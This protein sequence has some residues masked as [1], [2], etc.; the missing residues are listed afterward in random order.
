MTSILIDYSKASDTVDH[1]ILLKKLQNMNFAK[2]TIKIICSYLI[3]RYQYLQTED[4]SSNLLPM[5]FDVPQESI[6]GPVLFNLYV[7]E[8]ADCTYSKTIQYADDTTLY[9][10]WKI[11]TFHECVFAIQ[12]DV[13]KLLSWSQ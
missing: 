5:F 4:K 13:E 8:L 11:S 12:K 2:N 1:R 10:R 6:L 3:K 9:Q 7:A